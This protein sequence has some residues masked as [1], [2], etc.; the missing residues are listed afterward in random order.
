MKEVLFI[1]GG[2]RKNGNL[3]KMVEVA[4]DEA[5]RLNYKSHYINLYEKNIATC[6]G[7]MKCK[8]SGICILNDDI[9][10]IRELLI[11]CDLIVLASPTYFANVSAPVKNM[12][13]RLVGA[14]MDD[15]DNMIPKPKLSP[16]QKY[17]LM[18]TCN[19]PWPFDRIAKQSS[20]CINA[21]K[22]FL[23]I[24]GMKYK[25]KVIFAGT[26]NREELPKNIVRKIINL[27]DN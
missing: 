11:K 20:G 27:I 14:V 19:T 26:R 8:Q 1:F 12:F 18:T 3:S 23:N 17:I 13:D 15:N 5:N 24:S 6:R 25:G 16:K 2:P 21:M 4:M 22:E 9:Q 10:E 7:C